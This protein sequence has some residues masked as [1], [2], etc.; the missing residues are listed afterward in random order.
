M[1]PGDG[2]GIDAD[3]GCCAAESEGD[4]GAGP[5]EFECRGIDAAKVFDAIAEAFLEGDWAGW[6]GEGEGGEGEEGEEGEHRGVCEGK[7][8]GNGVGI[9][10]QFI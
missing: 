8:L 5:G 1:L 4:A 3:C 7:K 9:E 10:G 2:V 6:G